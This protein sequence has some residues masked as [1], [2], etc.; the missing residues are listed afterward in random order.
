[1]PKKRIM[2]VD[3][4]EAIRAVLGTSLKLLL[5][6]CQIRAVGNGDA[7]L[8]ELRQQPFDLVLTDY[9][10][11]RMNGV[12]LA[13][14]ARKISPR[15]RV[16]LMS[17]GYVDTENP[18]RTDALKLDGFLDKPFTFPQLEKILCSNGISISRHS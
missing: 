8:T 2:V 12:E 18:S 6:D 11:P 5:P 17:G 3:D 16:V 10:M 13:R 14:A 15:T 9:N 1:M 4:N 7:A